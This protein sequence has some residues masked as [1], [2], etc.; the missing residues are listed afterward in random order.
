MTLDC[1][2]LHAAREHLIACDPDYLSLDD[3]LG[4]FALDL[5]AEKLQDSG[6]RE[7][8]NPEEYQALTETVALAIATGMHVACET[9][10]R[11][12]ALRTVRPLTPLTGDALVARLQRLDPQTR[13]LQVW[14]PNPLHPDGY[15]RATDLVIGED[16][17]PA[18]GDPERFLSIIAVP[19]AALP[20]A[21][22]E[23]RSC[24]APDPEVTVLIVETNHDRTV[25][26]HW[27]DKDARAALASF[28][29]QAWAGVF[30]EE[31]LPVDADVAIE[32][33]FARALDDSYFLGSVTISHAA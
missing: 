33:Y 25:T 16:P 21:S 2:A 29:D 18:P 10:G 3:A 5:A 8:L 24:C 32:R 12:P 28:V 14:L 17:D 11:E 1:A 27:T 31:P 26:V 30:D 6:V 13:G 23:P 19:D 7:T 15:V 9:D 4:Q 20:D 22:G